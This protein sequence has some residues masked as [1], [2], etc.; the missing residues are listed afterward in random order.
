MKTTMYG[1]DAQDER[2]SRIGF[3][4][5]LEKL[6]M[7]ESESADDDVGEELVESISFESL[8]VEEDAAGAPVRHLTIG[9]AHLT[10]DEHTWD[11]IKDIQTG[12]EF[13]IC[14]TGDDGTLVDYHVTRNEDDYIIFKE[15]EA[16]GKSGKIDFTSLSNMFD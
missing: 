12:E 13:I 16:T 3:K 1:D 5:Y 10:M 11:A 8:M 15:Y 9:D 6:R 2:H 7:S 14:L 4:S